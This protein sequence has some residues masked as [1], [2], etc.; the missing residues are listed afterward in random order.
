MWTYPAF[1]S[2]VL[3]GAVGAELAHLGGGADALFD[4]LDAVLVG[5]VHEGQSLQV[6]TYIVKPQTVHTSDEYAQESKSSE[7]K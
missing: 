1:L 3:D 2:V 7:S 5:L 4:P 6:Y